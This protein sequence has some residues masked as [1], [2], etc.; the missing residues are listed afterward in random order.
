MKRGKVIAELKTTKENTI[1]RVEIYYKVGGSNL[2]TYK[3][4]KRGY[5]VSVSPLKVELGDGYRIESSTMFSGVKQLIKEA[6][7]FSQK[8]LDGLTVSAEIVQSLI[9]HV[10]TK[11]GLTLDGVSMIEDVNPESVEA[12]S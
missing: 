5:Y 11:N 9:T 4:E 7:R 2:F 6:A 8:E 12:V 3:I 1:L 10:T